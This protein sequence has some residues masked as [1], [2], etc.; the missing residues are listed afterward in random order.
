MRAFGSLLKSLGYTDSSLS[1]HVSR[2]PDITSF[3]TRLAIV[4]S[5]IAISTIELSNFLS[6]SQDERELFIQFP[7]ARIWLNIQS[8]KFFHILVEIS[9]ILTMQVHHNTV[10][11]KKR[12]F[13]WLYTY[14]LSPVRI[15]V[16]AWIYSFPSTYSLSLCNIFIN[17]IY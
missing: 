12:F 6:S 2:K 8:I 4:S 5:L 10:D 16:C 17:D 13:L 11:K 14:H 7:K 15:M 3:L 1:F 9:Q